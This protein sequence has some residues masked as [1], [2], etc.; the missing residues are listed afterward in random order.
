MLIED[1][2]SKH[3]NLNRRV[4]KLRL[5]YIRSRERIGSRLNV[6]AGNYFWFAYIER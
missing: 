3:Q 4:I 6:L 2:L 5:V 1:D